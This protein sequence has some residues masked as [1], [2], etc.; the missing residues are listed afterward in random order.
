MHTARRK[1]WDA[2]IRGLNCNARIGSVGDL[3]QDIGFNVIAGHPAVCS[4]IFEVLTL[5]SGRLQGGARELLAM[6]GHVRCRARIRE[7]TDSHKPLVSLNLGSGN[8][9]RPLL[10]AAAI[11]SMALV[12]SLPLD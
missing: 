11:L 2:H 6:V 3:V 12:A 7:G 1:S 8:R 4:C 5:S 10:T 9:I